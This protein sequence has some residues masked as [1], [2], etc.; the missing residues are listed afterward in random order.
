M[1]IQIADLTEDEQVRYWGML[2]VYARKGRERLAHRE[3]LR[4]TLETSGVAAAVVQQVLDKEDER[5][6]NERGLL[7]T[8]DRIRSGEDT[9]A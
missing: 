8:P 1:A 4:R 7:P 3:C 2:E 9:A 5:L 6:D